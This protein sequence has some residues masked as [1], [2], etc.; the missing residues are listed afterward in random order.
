MKNVSELLDLLN[1]EQLEYNLFRGQS[2]SIGSKRV[3]G[4]Q[5]L[6]QS[7]SAAMQTVPSDRFVHSL[8]AYFILPGDITMPIVFDVE[9]IRDG[10]VLPPGE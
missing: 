9:T 7:L 6:A 4:G 1:M 3:F 10:E 8:H 2:S 5:V